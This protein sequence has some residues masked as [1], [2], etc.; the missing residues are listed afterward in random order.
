MMTTPVP[1][2]T[3]LRVEWSDFVRKSLVS[4]VSAHSAFRTEEIRFMRSVA[5]QIP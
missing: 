4:I 3:M 2:K 5:E 1:H